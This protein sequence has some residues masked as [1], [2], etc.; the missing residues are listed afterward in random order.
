MRRNSWIVL[1]LAATAAVAAAEDPPPQRLDVGK[2]LIEAPVESAVRS[3]TLDP[4]ELKARPG[5][6]RW[7]AGLVDALAAAK[8][9]RRPVLV[10]QLLGN[11][12]QEFC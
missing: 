4:L 10:F 8:V 1:A 7:H 11:L 6:V 2:S 3:R 9:S 5:L 12:D